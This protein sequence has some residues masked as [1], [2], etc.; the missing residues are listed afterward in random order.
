MVTPVGLVKERLDESTS[1]DMYPSSPNPNRFSFKLSSNLNKISTVDYEGNRSP[2]GRHYGPSQRFLASEM[3]VPHCS[4]WSTDSN[5]A[6]RTAP[7]SN[8][9]EPLCSTAGGASF[10]TTSTGLPLQERR[11]STASPTR[12]AL[13]QDAFSD[14]RGY[15]F[16]QGHLSSHSTPNGVPCLNWCS[17]Q[18]RDE[19]CRAITFDKLCDK[20]GQGMEAVHTVYLSSPNDSHSSR[21][22]RVY[23]SSEYPSQ[24]S[25]VLRDTT[26]QQALAPRSQNRTHERDKRFNPWSAKAKS[27]STEAEGDSDRSPTTLRRTRGG[28]GYRPQDP[29]FYDARDSRPL[30]RRRQ[31][32]AWRSPRIFHRSKSHHGVEIDGREDSIERTT[33]SHTRF[34]GFHRRGHTNFVQT[35]SSSSTDR[36]NDDLVQKSVSIHEKNQWNCNNVF[37]SENRRAGNGEEGKPPESIGILGTPSANNNDALCRRAPFGRHEI[38]TKSRGNGN[39]FF[40]QNGGRQA[41]LPTPI[42]ENPNADCQCHPESFEP[43]M[44]AVYNYD[45]EPHNEDEGSL[46]PIHPSLA[47]TLELDKL[48]N[49]LWLTGC[50]FALAIAPPIL[51]ALHVIRDP[52]FFTQILRRKAARVSRTPPRFHKHLRS[53]CG[54]NIVERALM[55]DAAAWARFFTVVKSKLEGMVTLRT[56]FHTIDVN[57]GMP[58]APPVN[59]P[60]IPELLRAFRNC[61]FLYTTDMRHFFHQFG[62]HELIRKFFTIR[63]GKNTF[64]CRCMPMGWTWA[65][66][67][68]QAIAWWLA[69]GDVCFSWETLPPIFNFQGVVIV[70]WYDNLLFGGEKAKVEA[71]TQDFRARVRW[72]SGIVKEESHADLE[73]F[74]TFIGLELKPTRSGIQWRIAQKTL[75]KLNKWE[76]MLCEGH[77]ISDKHWES[78][79]GILVWCFWC[80]QLS[81]F[82]LVPLFRIITPL[83][84]H[85]E[86]SLSLIQVFSCNA[87]HSLPIL[88]RMEVTFTDASTAGWGIVFASGTSE[89]GTFVKSFT[90]A[91]IFFLEALAVKQ[92]VRALQGGSLL[93][94]GTDNKALMHTINR[95]CTACPRTARILHE[96]VESLNSKHCQMRAFFIP[97]EENPADELSRGQ[98]LKVKKLL[99]ALE[100]YKY[101]IL[102]LRGSDGRST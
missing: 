61:E 9:E 90:S 23:R 101:E 82:A 46:D 16:S 72:L 19:D 29:H 3:L 89:S 69:V 36:G 28:T 24:Q 37:N 87:W 25:A 45:D 17:P 85:L 50:I 38:A 7:E 75:A 48:L 98:Q 63:C 70:I 30:R 86:R 41:A 93:I 43:L 26:S 68:A 42:R 14:T 27:P 21:G 1:E 31:G 88:E 6:P 35:S 83:H 47:G 95:G 77:P 52:E 5:G 64:R 10:E 66:F 67:V 12:F 91:D 76:M 97:T 78:L 57:S 96:C 54:M 20:Y 18:R 56:I 92:A 13:Q 34:S 62:L 2:H 59:L 11:V 33:P 94:I 58:A 74:I 80:C 71:L 99:D 44:S 15:S 81:F 8:R 100:K 53:L 79:R 32:S 39:T 40:F 102:A 22:Y 84:E 4:V 51:I 65:P 73:N 49:H 60:S 55:E